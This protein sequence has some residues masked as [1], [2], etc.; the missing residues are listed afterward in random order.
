MCICALHSLSGSLFRPRF[1]GPGVTCH[2]VG[3]LSDG[4]GASYGGFYQGKVGFESYRVPSAVCTVAPPPPCS[5][6]KLHSEG[7][8]DRKR[9]DYAGR[10]Y[11]TFLHSSHKACTIEVTREMLQR[12]PGKLIILRHPEKDSHVPIMTQYAYIIK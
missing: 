9:L 4:I 11:Q 2:C 6:A 3:V 7:K 8:G 12:N 1:G 10:D 5:C